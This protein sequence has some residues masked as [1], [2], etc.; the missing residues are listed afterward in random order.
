MVLSAFAGMGI[1]FSRYPRSR[2]LVLLCLSYALLYT[3]THADI[4][5]RYRLVLDPWLLVFAAVFFR[6]FFYQ[7]P[8]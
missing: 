3:V 2:I 8:P 7:S 4:A 6:R 1:A 5:D